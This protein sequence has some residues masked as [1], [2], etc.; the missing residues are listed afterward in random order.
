[1]TEYQIIEVSWEEDLLRNR[2]HPQSVKV[3]TPGFLDFLKNK[4]YEYFDAGR[5]L[6]Y[7]SDLSLLLSS[8]KDPLSGV[9]DYKVPT[10][11][12]LAYYYRRGMVACVSERVKIIL[13]DNEVNKEEYILKPIRIKGLSEVY[14]LFF[15]PMI[16]RCSAHIVYDES[17]FYID[18]IDSPLHKQIISIRSDEDYRRIPNLK[19]RK[20]VLNT[21]NIDTRDIYYINGCNDVFFS[22][23]ITDAFSCQRI[24]GARI[25]PCGNKCTLFVKNN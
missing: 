24:I 13:E 18:D 22:K 25:V 6:D 14:Y 15:V 1:M 2:S 8:F 16:S 21:G 3:T 4:Y 7:Y 20:I 5:P 23:K 9:L 11:Y 19:P 17:E 12:M 10:D